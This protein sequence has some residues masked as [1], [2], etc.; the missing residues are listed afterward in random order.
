MPQTDVRLQFE[1]FINDVEGSKKLLTSTG[2]GF[3]VPPRQ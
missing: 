3:P 2:Y 1:N